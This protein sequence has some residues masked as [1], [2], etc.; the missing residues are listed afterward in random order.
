MSNELQKYRN[1]DDVRIDKFG[2]NPI[3]K[4]HKPRKKNISPKNMI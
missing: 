3:L 4:F 2:K 1:T